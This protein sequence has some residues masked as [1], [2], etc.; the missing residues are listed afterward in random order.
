TAAAAS[1]LACP[2]CFVQRGQ[3][4]QTPRAAGA[5][6]PP[7]HS[8][9]SGSEQQPGWYRRWRQA[10]PGTATLTCLQGRHSGRS[11][12]RHCLISY[13]RAEA[14]HVA[15]VLKD[16]DE[17]ALGSDWQDALN[18]AVAAHGSGRNREVKLA[19]VLGKEILVL[20]ASSPT[21]HLAA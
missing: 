1:A 8:S 5:P 18:D 21:G 17:I 19:D 3:P 10:A 14:A 7:Q 16:V 11:A 2:R 9:L 6:Y 12:A 4:P 20:S 13:V 15:V